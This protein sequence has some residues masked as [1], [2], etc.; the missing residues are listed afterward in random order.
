MLNKGWESNTAAD[1]FP[2]CGDVQ[3]KAL[4]LQGGPFF[5][6]GGGFGTSMRDFVP[7]PLDPAYDCFLHPGNPLCA[8]HVYNSLRIQLAVFD[9]AIWNSTVAMIAGAM[10]L[11]SMTSKPSFSPTN[12][13]APSVT[14]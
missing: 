12:P 2:R 1:P 6:W 11:W 9:L 8:R 5:G 4:H 3:S 13:C 7:S 14:K 10:L